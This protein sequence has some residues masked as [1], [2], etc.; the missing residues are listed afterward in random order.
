MNRGVAYAALAYALWGMFPVYFK[1][2]QQVP[3]I[4]ILANRVVWTLIV[5]ITLLILMR[6]WRWLAAL[7]GQ[8]R[9]LAWFA[10]S[11][12]LI[13]VN[14]GLYIWAVNA[15]R[16]VDASLGYFINPLVNV[17]LGVIVLHERL[18]P[19]Q[20]I[21]V[22]LAASGVLWLSIAAGH[23]PW[24]GMT[25]AISWG[26]YGL[27]R[28]TGALGS[29]EGLTVETSLL[30]PLAAGY[31]LFLAWHG[32]NHLADADVSTRALL[33]AAGPITAV[34]LLLFAAAARRIT[35]TSLGLMQYI[36]PTLQF[37]LGVWLYQEPFDATRAVGFV[38]VWIAL[39]VFS[40]EGLAR[41]RLAARAVT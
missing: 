17:L 18:R 37:A 20:W 41:L 4:E 22:A 30:L 35:L 28:K 14:W 34:P 16:V 36:S 25:L 19:A 1:L 12:A 24:I 15:G 26:A 39:L 2:L 29:V 5:C 9:V 7:A 31:L 38:L 21:A 40:I 27:L 33:L 13:S 8:P 11:A 23:V 32:N 3:A 10:G 6:R